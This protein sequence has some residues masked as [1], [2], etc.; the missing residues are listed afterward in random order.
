MGQVPAA[1]LARRERLDPDAAGR[2]RGDPRG[3]VQA[4]RVKGAAAQQD[5][6]PPPAQQ[7]DGLLDRRVRRLAPGRGRHE[8]ERR[9]PRSP[10]AVGRDDQRRHSPRGAQGRCNRRAARFGHLVRGSDGARP[11]H[12]GGEGGDVGCQRGVQR[13]VAGGVIAD[14]VDDG[15]ARP[16]CVVQVGQAVGE[17]GAQVQEGCGRAARHAC[18]AVGRAGA[19]ALEQTEDDPDAVHLFE[20]RDDGHF[21]G[22]GIGKADFHARPTGGLDQAQGSC[23]HRILP[24]GAV[25]LEPRPP[26]NAG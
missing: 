10:L 3:G 12:T 8:I 15:G 24:D 6:A 25:V 26:I 20:G 9:G 21:G 4:L 11:A 1:L 23:K 5:A 7:A 19:H 22:A 13:Q 16:A 2:C 14:P 18:P 17:A